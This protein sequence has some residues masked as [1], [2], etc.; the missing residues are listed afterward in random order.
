[1]G[2]IYVFNNLKW[3]PPIAAKYLSTP[4]VQLNLA[5]PDDEIKP[6]VAKQRA[7]FDK[8]FNDAFN[9]KFDAQGK[10]K[11]K[12]IQ[13]AVKDFESKLPGKTKEQAAELVNTANVL[14]KQAIAVWQMEMQKLCD[15]CATK[16]YEESVKAM[17]AKLVK[18]Q[19]K[20]V[21]KIVLVGALILTAAGLAIAATVVTGGAL[22]PIV[23]GA[24]VTGGTALYKV[25]K[26]YD[27]EWATASNKIKEIQGDITKL[28]AA[29]KSYKKS[30]TLYA[31]TSEKL[32]AFKA[33]DGAGFGHR[34]ARRPVGQ[35]H[36]RAAQQ[37]EGTERQVR[38]TGSEDQGGRLAGSRSFAQGRQGVAGEG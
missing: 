35:V 23:L 17:K 29:I 30:E 28:E 11:T 8:K 38:G 33:A 14:L 21:C 36:L 7:I 6:M 20:S 31:G 34:Q 13:D 25:Y 5:Y 1:M 32:S 19:I 22:A 27:G 37:P 26:L 4:E 10:A 16:A 15:E 18:A 3:K 12:V 9:S 24:L 2:M